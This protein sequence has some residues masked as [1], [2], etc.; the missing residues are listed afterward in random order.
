MQ[1][2]AH[3]AESDREVVTIHLSAEHFLQRFLGT[4]QAVDRKLIDGIERGGKEW[5]SLNMVP[6][7]VAYKD[8]TLDRFL[9]KL[10]KQ[11]LAKHPDAGACVENQQLIAA[12]DFSA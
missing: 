3:V 5:E 12:P 10:L 4:V 11:R 2:S 7:G 6:M 1:V 9:L 8:V